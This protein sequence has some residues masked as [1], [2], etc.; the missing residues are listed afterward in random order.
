MRGSPGF[1][2]RRPVRYNA[3]HTHGQRRTFGAVSSEVERFV[4]TEEVI[5]SIPIL[6]ILEAGPNLSAPLLAFLAMLR[7]PKAKTA[8]PDTAPPVGDNTGSKVGPVHTRNR[9]RGGR[10]L[11]HSLKRVWV[12]HPWRAMNAPA[13]Q[14][15]NQNR[16]SDCRNSRAGPCSGSNSKHFSS[17][18][19][20]SLRL[21]R[22]AIW[23]ACW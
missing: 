4:D 18:S 13:R 22:S 10:A 6:P 1:T 2:A 11:F 17:A 21:P 14:R 23:R 20:A 7:M 5:G 12:R 9:D 16:E 3:P 8:S 15:A 19:R